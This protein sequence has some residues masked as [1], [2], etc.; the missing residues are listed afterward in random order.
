MRVQGVMQRHVVTLS[1]NDTLRD[2]YELMQEGG[3]RHIPILDDEELVGIVSDRD[4]LLQATSDDGDAAVPDML[5]ADIMT[6]DLIT[7]SATARLADVAASMVDH[8]IDALP[9]MDGNGQLVGIVTSTDLLLL[10]GAADHEFGKTT[11]P[12][13][14]HIERRAGGLRGRPAPLHVPI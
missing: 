7:C 9:V 4:I 6:T 12:F 10:V 2:A 1:P 13:S 3:F 14:Y 8:K 5:L 11:L